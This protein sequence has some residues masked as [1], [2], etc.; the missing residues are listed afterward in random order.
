M[1]FG[2]SSETPRLLPP[3]LFGDCHRVGATVDEMQ[4]EARR[5]FAPQ[6]PG[7]P[8][9]ED[10]V[11]RVFSRDPVPWLRLHDY[12]ARMPPSSSPRRWL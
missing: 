3:P 12:Q 9:A 8:S 4:A 10:V 7:I 2:L 6:V 5:C 1:S 11:A